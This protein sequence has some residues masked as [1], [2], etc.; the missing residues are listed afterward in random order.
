MDFSERKNNLA[1][2][3]IKI[4]IYIKNKQTNKN[5]QNIL[6]VNIYVLLQTLRLSFPVVVVAMQTQRRFLLGCL[7]EVCFLVTIER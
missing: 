7:G 3:D 5:K 2:C 4:Y 6:W 1:Y